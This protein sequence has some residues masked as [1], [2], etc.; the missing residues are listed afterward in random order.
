MCM[1]ERPTYI[2]HHISGETIRILLMQHFLSRNLVGSNV[3]PSQQ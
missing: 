1:A 2:S 3:T